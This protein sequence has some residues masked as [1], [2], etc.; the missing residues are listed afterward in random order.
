MKS[1]NNPNNNLNISMQIKYIFQLLYH[2]IIANMKQ[3][4]NFFII[5]FLMLKT[6]AFSQVQDISFNVQSHFQ[7]IIKSANKISDN[8][9][10]ADTI[11]KISQFDYTINS[12]P[13]YKKYQLQA[14][15]FAKHKEK[16]LWNA[17][18]SYIKAGYGFMYNM[19]MLELYYGNKNDKDLRYGVYY[20]LLTSN[21]QLNN[22]GYSGFT[23]HLASIFAEKYIVKHLIKFNLDYSNN[24][25]YNYGFDTSINKI[26][27]KN[28]YRQQYYYWSPSLK[29]KSNYTDSSKIH[30][31]ILISYYNLQNYQDARENNIKISTNLNTF[32]HQ[33]NFFL[34]IS[35]DYYNH[36]LSK[37][38]LNNHIFTLSP[39]FLSKNEDIEIRVG[40]KTTLDIFQY[41]KF[42]FY[43]VFF[44]NYNLYRHI[45]EIFAGIDGQLQKNS[46]KSLSDE[47]PFINTSFYSSNQ[48][49]HLTN[50]NQS[51]NIYAGFKGKL[52]SQTDY[53]VYGTYERWDSL[54]FFNI[55]YQKNMSIDNQYMIEYDNTAQ[56]KLNTQI[57]YDANNKLQLSA[58]GNYYYYQ[59]KNFTKP[60]QKPI[61]KAQL[62]SKYSL[63][64]HFQFQLTGF[65]IGDRWAKV[66][67][68]GNIRNEMLPPIIDLNFIAEYKRN[69]KLSV[70]VMLN[71]IANM[72][73]YRWYNYPS[74]RF[75]LM[76][77]FNYIPF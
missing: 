73:Y 48:N 10:V 64:E 53:V 45:I 46:I 25:L 62:S 6:L 4:I 70:F 66:N 9:E 67:L 71:N 33:E 59:L 43:P 72:R 58:S 77:G 32:I 22:V 21:K 68:Y 75:N 50:S 31:D 35:Y 23:D 69:K 41:G 34:N 19:P 44:G 42:Y 76:L 52:S 56:Y 8:P 13:V 24:K 74:Q 14:L 63:N 20:N 16:Y 28:L 54:H 65:L 18:Q 61:Y 5:L 55:Y 7:P 3:N 39:Y 1:I 51:I 26:S 37:D 47:N 11:R 49:I 30:H 40:V 38:T 57:R 27:D 60:W 29:I 15:T 36:K 12:F 2:S 17:H